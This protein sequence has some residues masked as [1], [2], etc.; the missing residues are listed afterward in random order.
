M[1]YR[2]A[3]RFSQLIFVQEC[4][5]SNVRCWLLHLGTKENRITDFASHRE[6]TKATEAIRAAGWEPQWM[7]ISNVLRKWE[8]QLHNEAKLFRSFDPQGELE[9]GMDEAI[10][11]VESIYLDLSRDSH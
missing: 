1:G 4:Q 7:D 5:A 2:P 10:E 9:S 6:L 3:I 11:R 8:F